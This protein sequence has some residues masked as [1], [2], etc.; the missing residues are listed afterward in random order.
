M[1][2]ATDIESAAGGEVIEAVVIGPFGWLADGWPDDEP[3]EEALGWDD[4]RTPVPPGMKGTPLDW[5]HA[6]PYLDYSYDA[7]FGGMDCHDVTAWTASWVL[8]V[9]EYDG[10]TSVER[11]PRNPAVVNEEW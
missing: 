1:S 9:H 8:Y 4:K 7:G 5:N 6:R 2:F 10:S 11:I 3:D